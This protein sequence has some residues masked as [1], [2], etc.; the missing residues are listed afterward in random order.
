MAER[1][2]ATGSVEVSSHGNAA[3]G[4]KYH[5]HDIVELGARLSK[6]AVGSEA[7]TW[8]TFEVG[9]T[10]TPLEL[11]ADLVDV[12][13]VAG[14]AEPL[15]LVDPSFGRFISSASRI[16]PSPPEGLSSFA[17]FDA[18]PQKE[19]VQLTLHQLRAGCLV[20]GDAY[21]GGGTLFLVGKAGNRQRAV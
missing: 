16:F 7:A 20:L 21:R 10:L 17:G 14:T 19:Y 8:S 2:A 1:R 11:Q 18:G 15:R 3:G 6:V 5:L 4:F 9:A 13:D 12:P